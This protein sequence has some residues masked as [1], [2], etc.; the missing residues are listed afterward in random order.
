MKTVI[1]MA[2][3]MTA[4]YFYF[5]RG[6]ELILFYRENEGDKEVNKQTINN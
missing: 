6:V 4:A 5:I 2:C 3:R 1:F